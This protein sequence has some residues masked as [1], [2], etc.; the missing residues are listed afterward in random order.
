VTIAAF[1]IPADRSAERWVVAHR[2]A[3]LDHPFT[4]LT[5]AGS[6]GALWL[7]L[8]LV[9][10]FALRRPAL[11]VLVALADLC[12][13]LLSDLLKVIVD[14]P[15]PHV[16]HLVA[17]PH[18]GSF[19][20]GHSATSFACA[21]V[22]AALVPRA[23]VPAYVLA[24]AVA[25]SRLYVGVHYPLDVLAGAA[26]GIATARPLLAAARRRSRPAPRSG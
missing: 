14:R 8:A 3:W 15:R 9:L 2:V 1:S 21:T 4:W 22:L 11:F 10:A 7:V 20:S 6:W 18:S 26:L 16:S 13:D 17:V 19:P 5:R 23:A 25:F 12:A 24:A